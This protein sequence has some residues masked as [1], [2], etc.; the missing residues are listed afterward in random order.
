MTHSNLHFTKTNGS[1][2]RSFLYTQYALHMMSLQL[3]PAHEHVVYCRHNDLAWNIRQFIHNKLNT[4]NFSSDLRQVEPWAS[5][6]WSHTDI[7]RLVQGRLGAQ[8]TP[9]Q[10]LLLSVIG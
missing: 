7:P 9:R 10:L 5:S 6:K 8:V 4:V 1:N 2:N 3:S